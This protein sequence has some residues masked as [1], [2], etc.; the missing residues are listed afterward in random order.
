MRQGAVGLPE[1][2]RAAR[3]R[4]YLNQSK[5]SLLAGLGRVTVYNIEEQRTQGNVGIIT[6]EKLAKVLHVS[7]CWLAYGVGSSEMILHADEDKPSTQRD[8]K[9]G[10]GPHLDQS[11]TS[12]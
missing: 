1:R 6:V 12:K 9:R 8:A 10:H 2:L 5:L 7:P 11:P 4:M 3:E